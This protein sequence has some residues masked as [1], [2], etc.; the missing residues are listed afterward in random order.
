MV[1]FNLNPYIYCYWKKRE[2]KFFEKYE[3][4]IDIPNI[5]IFSK[6]KISSS[7]I[8]YCLIISDEFGGQLWTRIIK[9]K[10]RYDKKKIR[11]L[12]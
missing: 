8:S 11:N 10:E 12:F 7:A 3:G 5:L 6:F 4:G 1:I 2:D 9:I